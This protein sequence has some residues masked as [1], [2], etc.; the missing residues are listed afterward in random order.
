[1][2]TA[3]RQRAL[4]ATN[5][6]ILCQGAPIS[7]LL[8]ESRRRSEN[9]KTA[10]DYERIN[11]WLETH[12]KH[13]PKTTELERIFVELESAIMVV[14]SLDSGFTEPRLAIAAIRS[15]IDKATAALQ[16][17]T[18][19]QQISSS[20]STENSA[21]FLGQSLVEIPQEEEK[22][23]VLESASKTIHD[24]HDS[25]LTTI[26]D[27]N[28]EV[29]F[30]AE[31]LPGPEST[32][33]FSMS[34]CTDDRRAPQAAMVLADLQRALSARK[35]HIVNN[36]DQFITSSNELSSLGHTAS[37]NDLSRDPRLSMVAAALSARF[38]CVHSSMPPS[39]S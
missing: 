14:S 5:D 7:A 33:T 26:A 25:I 21:V 39:F 23:Y 31:A 29:V 8:K 9:A 17:Y 10:R 4:E 20:S 1:M 34:S 36:D 37:F 24:K 2:A 13:R 16:Q 11:T 19:S 35:R 32:G 30:T 18:L 27:A 38:E 12:L 6:T 22:Q 15:H 28:D 3:R